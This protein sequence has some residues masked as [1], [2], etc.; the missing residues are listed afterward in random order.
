MEAMEDG[1]LIV[2]SVP[3]NPY[4][5]PPGPY[6]RASLIA[7]YLKTHKPKS[8]L[9]VLDSKDQFSKQRLFQDAWKALYPD[10]L[11]YV[12]LAGGGKTVE[13]IA[14]EKTVVT[15][16]GRHKGAVVNVIPPQRAGEIAHTAG[17]ADRSGWCPID[18]VT[19]ESRLRPFIHVIGDASIA[20]AMATPAATSSEW[21]RSGK[22]AS[23]WTFPG[24]L[25]VASSRQAS[26][27]HRPRPQAECSGAGRIGRGWGMGGESVGGRHPVNRPPQRGTHERPGRFGLDCRLC[28]H[29]RRHG[30]F[31]LRDQDRSLAGAP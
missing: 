2:M 22:E 14:A 16:F 23:G 25:A 13:V 19:F 5:C 27:T 26:A 10:H 6:E 17:C 7:H 20:G 9:I 15:E 28:H 30:H 18:P 24:F 12:P 3:A 29:P 1:G 31:P 21:S 11:E 8:K 4:R